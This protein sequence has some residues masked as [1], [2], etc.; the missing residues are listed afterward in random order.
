[1]IGLCTLRLW[2]ETY[3]LQVIDDPVIGKGPANGLIDAGHA[4]ADS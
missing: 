2:R 3:S 1:M 4:F